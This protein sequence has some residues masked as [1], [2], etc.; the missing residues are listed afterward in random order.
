LEI[1]NSI[2]VSIPACHAGDPGSIPGFGVFLFFGVSHQIRVSFHVIGY[3]FSACVD[4]E[5][6]GRRNMQGSYIV[7]IVQ[8]EGISPG[9]NRH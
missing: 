5:M 4:I 1:R 7:K 8:K 3:S 9:K 6:K 2:E